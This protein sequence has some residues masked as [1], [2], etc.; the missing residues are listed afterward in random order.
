[1]SCIAAVVEVEPIIIIIIIIII[2]MYELLF[3]N[4]EIISGLSLA[5]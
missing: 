4:C 3:R 1:M 5:R 2:I